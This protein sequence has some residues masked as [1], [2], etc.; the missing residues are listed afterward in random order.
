MARF[1][2]VKRIDE[3]SMLPPLYGVAWQDFYRRRA[4][5][6]PVPL[7]VVAGLLRAAWLYMRWG[8]IPT[9]MNP[10]AAYDKGFRDGKRAAQEVGE[11][12]GGA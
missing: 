10:R 9:P 3:G 11:Q 6:L 1:K 7:N 2:I 4:V 12:K 5:C 8:W